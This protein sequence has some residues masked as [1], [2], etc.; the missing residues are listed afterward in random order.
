MPRFYNKAK[1]MFNTRFGNPEL[2]R[3]EPGSSSQ[4]C[5]ALDLRILVWHQG[6]LRVANLFTDRNTLRIARLLPSD[7]RQ[8]NWY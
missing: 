8:L 1:K 6:F 3:I 5:S 4:G 7:M 2:T